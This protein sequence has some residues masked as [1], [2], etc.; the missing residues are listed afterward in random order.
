[1]PIG[2]VTEAHLRP[3]AVAAVPAQRRHGLAAV[4]EPQ[5]G[6]PP[7]TRIA[8]GDPDA[9][10]EIIRTYGGMLRAVTHRFRLTGDEADDAVQQT[11]LALFQHAEQLR[12]PACI[13]GWLATTVRRHCLAIRRQRWIVECADEG[14]P[15]DVAAD[16]VEVDRYVVQAEEAAALH[17]AVERLPSREKAVI[18]ALMATQFSDYR[19]ISA[20]LAMP[21]GSIGP[22]RGRALRRLRRSLGDTRFDYD[23]RLAVAR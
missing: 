16:G 3:R 10:R 13:G 7:L 21:I 4:P 9:W 23:A 2:E 11:W 12:D 8:A 15:L 5:D 14:S 20:S 22:I 18:R 1:M 6:V 17:G 19:V